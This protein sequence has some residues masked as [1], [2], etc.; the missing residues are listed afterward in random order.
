MGTDMIRHAST[1]T[2]AVEA[3]YLVPWREAVLDEP[4]VERGTRYS[5]LVPKPSSV[6]STVIPNV[7]NSKETGVSLPTTPADFPIGLNYSQFQSLII[8]PGLGLMC[9]VVAAHTPS[10]FGLVSLVVSLVVGFLVC[11]VFICH[12]HSRLLWI[13]GLINPN[14]RRNANYV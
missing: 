13:M 3:E 11:K 12:D 10:Q 5:R 6:S 9:L 4:S 2:V 14:T 1:A 7:V 8:G